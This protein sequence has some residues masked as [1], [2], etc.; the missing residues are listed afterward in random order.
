MVVFMRGQRRSTRIN[1]HSRFH[2]LLVPLDPG[3]EHV[4]FE[5]PE[6]VDAAGEAGIG[7]GE[8][9]HDQSLNVIGALAVQID[10][11]AQGS[12]R[13]NWLCSSGIAPLISERRRRRV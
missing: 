2:P 4:Q 3:H 1:A 6:F 7:L 13:S 10:P 8:P 9:A 11:E 5:F 12:N